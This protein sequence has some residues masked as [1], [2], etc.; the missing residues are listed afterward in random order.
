MSTTITPPTSSSASGGGEQDTSTNAVPLAPSVSPKKTTASHSCPCCCVCGAR[1]TA[2][3]S[4]LLRCGRCKSIWYCGPAHQKQ[5]WKTHKISCGKSIEEKQTADI[6]KSV[7]SGHSL[8]LAFGGSLYAAQHE[9]LEEKKR[10][11]AARKSGDKVQVVDLSGDALLTLAV[12]DISVEASQTRGR[13]FS[14]N[15]TFIGPLLSG[16][17][18][19]RKS[20]CESYSVQDFIEEHRGKLFNKSE[21]GMVGREAQDKRDSP[22]NNKQRL[23]EDSG[24]SVLE[25]IPGLFSSLIVTD[26]G[27]VLKPLRGFEKQVR[28]LFDGDVARTKRSSGAA[29]TQ[30]PASGAGKDAGGGVGMGFLTRDENGLLKHEPLTRKNVKQVRQDALKEIEKTRQLFARRLG[31]GKLPA[32]DLNDSDS[33]DD[34]DDFYYP[35]YEGEGGHDHHE[36]KTVAQNKTMRNNIPLQKRANGPMP[37]PLAVQLTL[38]TRPAPKIHLLTAGE[39]RG[40]ISDGGGWGR[41]RFCDFLDLD[42]SGEPG[43]LFLSSWGALAKFAMKMHDPAMVLSGRVKKDQLVLGDNFRKAEWGW[44]ELW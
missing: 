28:K 23:V 16:G 5:D 17:P 11:R 13:L 6:H 25:E 40:R 12:E 41:S 19:L 38:I 27:E 30:G 24:H 35:D 33:S 15:N 20:A 22:R 2:G 7:A 10:Q 18:V 44:V 32:L 4:P 21:G 39:M 29:T 36:K 43:T 8:K 34:E 9:E 42:H 3:G 26:T 37:S 1:E 31:P 14:S